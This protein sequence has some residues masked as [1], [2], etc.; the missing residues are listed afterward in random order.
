MNYPK[1]LCKNDK[2][3]YVAPSCGCAHEPYYTKVQSS[4]KVM[5]NRGYK[6]E[7][8]P[9]VY[10]DEAIGRSNTATECAKEINHLHLIK[11]YNHLH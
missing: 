10:K 2:I 7:C 6:I 3:A 1:F 5:T 4:I 9:N 11:H 8:G